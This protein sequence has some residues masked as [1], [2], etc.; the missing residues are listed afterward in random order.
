VASGPT[1]HDVAAL[2]DEKGAFRLGDL[3]PGPY[4][5]VVNAEGFASVRARVNVHAD[6][7]T[8]VAITLDESVPEI[9]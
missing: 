4:E 9:D 7:V 8:R 5:L 1:H 2:T 6:V 3:K